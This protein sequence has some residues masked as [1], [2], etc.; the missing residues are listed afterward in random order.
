[1]A[2]KDKGI[3]PEQIQDTYETGAAKKTASLRPMP[4]T[5]PVP[6]EPVATNIQL[7]PI[8]QPLAFVPY[9][10]QKQPL[11]VYDGEE[12]VMVEDEVPYEEAPVNTEVFAKVKAKRRVSGT[13]LFL[14]ISGLIILAAL[15]L[16][17]FVSAIA[18]YTAVTVT[19]DPEVFNQGYGLVEGLVKNIKNIIDLNNVIPAAIALVGVLTVL[20]ILVSLICV[21]KKGAVLFVKISLFFTLAAAGIA[22]IMCITNSVKIGIGLYIVAGLVFL[23]TVVAYLTPRKK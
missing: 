14:I 6:V 23:Q 5:G 2:R 4:M 12:E 8:V 19:G 1:M 13:A 18:K 10:T 11:L 7:T 3:V 9:S 20:N 22:V 17:Q 16:G 15:I 21:C